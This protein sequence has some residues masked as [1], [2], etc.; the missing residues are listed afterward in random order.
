MLSSS[1]TLIII[2]AAIGII[3]SLPAFAFKKGLLPQRFQKS[4]IEGAAL[5]MGIFFFAIMAWVNVQAQTSVTNCANDDLGNVSCA[6]L[7]NEAGVQAELYLQS[8]LSPLAVGNCVTANASA[9]NIVST[10]L[11][12]DRAFLLQGWTGYFLMISMSIIMSGVMYLSATYI[13]SHKREETLQLVT[14]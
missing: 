9:C 10:H 4:L 5:I 14:A 6:V 13:T 2:S 8:L 1:L 11:T 3:F 7:N 12:P